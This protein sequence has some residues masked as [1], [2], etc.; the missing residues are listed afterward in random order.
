MDDFPLD[1]DASAVNDAHFTEPALDSLV[2]VLLYHYRDFTR[3]KGM[4]IDRVFDRN[5]VHSIKYNQHS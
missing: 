2:Q 3:L 4:E 5:L 1:S